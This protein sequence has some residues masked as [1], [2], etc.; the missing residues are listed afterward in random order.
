MCVM[1]KIGIT[2]KRRILLFLFIYFV[3]KIMKKKNTHLALF[4]VTN[5]YLTK[6][7][8]KFNIDMIKPKSIWDVLKL[9]YDQTKINIIFYL[10]GR[11]LGCYELKF[12]I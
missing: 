3:L 9:L 7:F 11:D 10:D 4:C 6:T 1:K 12:W 8:A 2:Q 5:L